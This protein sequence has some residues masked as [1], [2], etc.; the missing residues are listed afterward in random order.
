MKRRDLLISSAIG[1]A[2]L[3]LNKNTMAA[4]VSSSQSA[5]VPIA[6]K[7]NGVVPREWID[8]ISKK[9]I[10]RL[11]QIDNSKSLYFHDNAFTHDSRYMVMNTP[12]GIGLYDFSTHSH[13]LL[14]EGRY[15]VIMVSYSKPICY[16]RKY[17]GEFKGKDNAKLFDNVEYYA[18]DIPSGKQTFIGIF[19][20][21]FITSIN[22]DD[23]LMAGAATS[24]M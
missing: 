17:T 18:I 5:T 9:K 20:K 3:M 14:A 2:L 6:P 23:T 4:D 15:E 10:I 22:A 8:P 12:R 24:P 21:G 1:S 11:S 19:P 7:T 13:S 16:A